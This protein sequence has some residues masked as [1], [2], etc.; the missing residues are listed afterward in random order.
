VDVD[1]DVLVAPSILDF[2]MSLVDDMSRSRLLHLAR[3]DASCFLSR[4]FVAS[5]C[6]MTQSHCFVHGRW[7]GIFITR[8]I[9]VLLSLHFFHFI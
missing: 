5:T 8:I 2:W 1:V 9:T 3:Y 6:F 4:S 7:F